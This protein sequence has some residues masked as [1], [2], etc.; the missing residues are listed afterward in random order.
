MYSFTC[1]W[2][3]G[4]QNE[5][6]M[7]LSQLRAP[8]IAPTLQQTDRLRISEHAHHNFRIFLQPLEKL[9]SFIPTCTLIANSVSPR[10]LR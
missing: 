5:R 2:H 10:H 6:H 7:S 4:V 9:V 8:Q 1:C 3:F